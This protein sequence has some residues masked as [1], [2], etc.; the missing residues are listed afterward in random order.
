[1]RTCNHSD[2]GLPY[3]LRES[4]DAITEKTVKY[5][6]SRTSMAPTSLGPWK[7]VRDMDSSSH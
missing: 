4:L 1:M 3:A 5:L 6:Y 2:Q 7:F